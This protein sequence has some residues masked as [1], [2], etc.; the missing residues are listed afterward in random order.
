MQQ[1][2]GIGA[3]DAHPAVEPA[4]RESFAVGAET[5]GVDAGMVPRRGGDSLA[6]V[7]VVDGNLVAGS[8]DRQ[9]AS[10]GADGQGEDLAALALE[11]SNQGRVVGDQHLS[12]PVHLVEVGDTILTADDDGVAI[13]MAYD[14]RELSS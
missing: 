11:V 10:V 12:R 4:R 13:R 6:R 1:L 9:P 14:G 2:S 3:V 8:R 5:H 7:D